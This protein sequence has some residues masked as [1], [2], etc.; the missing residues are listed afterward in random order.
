[1]TSKLAKGMEKCLR[2]RLDEIKQAPL[3]EIKK[4]LS[5]SDE[6]VKINDKV[7]TLAIWKNQRIDGMIEVVIQ[8]YYTGLLYR[9]LGAGMMTADG[10]LIDNEGNF[11]KLP[12][13]IRWKY[14]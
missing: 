12:D 5:Y 10:F 1:M 4:L 7:C 14:C 6:E 9:L 3:S 2:D 11:F 8:I 13:E